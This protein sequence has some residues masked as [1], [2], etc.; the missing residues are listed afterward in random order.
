MKCPICSGKGAYC[1]FCDGTGKVT[2]KRFA[3]GM[4]VLK[5]LE[6]VRKLGASGEGRGV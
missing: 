3:F 4:T 2:K 6:M 1:D 5:R